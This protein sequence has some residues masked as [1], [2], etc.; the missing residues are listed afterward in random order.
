MTGGGIGLFG[1]LVFQLLHFFPYPVQV[2]FIGEKEL[3]VVALDYCMYFILKCVNVVDELGMIL[4]DLLFVGEFFGL[5]E[6]GIFAFFS[7]VCAGAS[8]WVKVGW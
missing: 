6:E 7:S 8:F 4:G 1:I 3:R 2:V 5:S